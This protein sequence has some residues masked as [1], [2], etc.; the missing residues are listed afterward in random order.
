[1]E[2]T[3][4]Q[5]MVM[6]VRLEDVSDR[7]SCIAYVG[8]GTWFDGKHFIVTQYKANPSVYYFFVYNDQIPYNYFG[9]FKGSYGKEIWTANPDN[10]EMAGTTYIYSPS[11]DRLYKPFSPNPNWDNSPAFIFEMK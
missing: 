5:R 7:S 6:R 9:D 2:N 8:Q 4:K 10:G 3:T 1:M 11:L